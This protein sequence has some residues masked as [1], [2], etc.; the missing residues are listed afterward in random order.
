MVY[1]FIIRDTENFLYEIAPGGYELIVENVNKMM[2]VGIKVQ[3]NS[4]DSS[5]EDNVKKGNYFSGYNYKVGLYDELIK[6]YEE[7]T[8]KRGK[9]ESLNKW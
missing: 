1:K 6:K 7:I 3:E 2:K 8:S 5:E 4:F 9:R